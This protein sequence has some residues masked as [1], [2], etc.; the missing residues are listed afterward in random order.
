MFRCP[1][2]LSIHQVCLTPS[3]AT[4]ALPLEHK[5]SSIHTIYTSHL[6]GRCLCRKFNHKTKLHPRAFFLGLFAQ[7]SSIVLNHLS[8]GSSFACVSSLTAQRGRIGIQHI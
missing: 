2:E 1:F 6:L 5:Q 7:A 4:L 8:G 3:N